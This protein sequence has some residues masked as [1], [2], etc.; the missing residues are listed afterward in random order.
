MRHLFT[1]MGMGLFVIALFLSVL[2][3]RD[4]D[5]SYNLLLIK[6]AYGIELVDRALYF[7]FALDSTSLYL[8]GMR[9]FFFAVIFYFASF[10]ILLYQ[11]LIRG[12]AK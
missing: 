8:K 7:D 1:Y 6:K 11:I 3:Y 4:I 12:D 2:A 9:Q 5:A 10:F